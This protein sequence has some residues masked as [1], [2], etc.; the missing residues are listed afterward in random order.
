MNGF[1]TALGEITLVLFTTLAPSAVFAFGVLCVILAFVPLEDA[2]RQRI[3]TY[4]CIPLVISMVGLVASAT[5]LGNPANA[6]YVFMGVGRS[7][8][9]TEVFFAVIFLM[10]AGIYWLYSFS[11]K[12]NI[13]L[14]RIWA[15]ATAV[16]GAVFIT[17]IA[18][19]Y[20]SETI[21][22]WYTVYVPLNVWLSAAV[23]GPLV[24][25]VSLQAAKA[26][27]LAARFGRLLC[28][29]AAGALVANTVSLCLQNAELPAIANSFGSAADLVPFYGILIAVF[30]A[31]GAAAI[32]IV[33]VPLTRR[34]ALPA[35]PASIA[36]CLLAYAG[37][38]VIRFAFYMMHMTVGLSV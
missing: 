22:S 9:S 16:A 37:I 38:F 25:L 34:G 3:N 35:L 27:E 21:A 15:G 8:L 24:A 20:Q 23:G 14:Q 17:A 18:F 36:A 4:L 26:D 33:A 13:A 32:A 28:L 19:A 7:P 29:I 11:Q 1:E 30:F 6:L 12:P 31:C 10:L 5:H 2:V